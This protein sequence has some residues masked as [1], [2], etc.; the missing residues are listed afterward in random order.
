MNYYELFEISPAAPIEIIESAYKKTAKKYHPDTY[1]GADKKFAE[2]QMKRLNEAIAIL[3][4]VEKRKNYDAK[5]GIAIERKRGY[6]RVIDIAD[7][8]STGERRNLQFGKY[9]W[10]VLDIQGGKALIITEDIIERRPYNEIL[11]EVNWENCTLR[12]DYLNIEFL[13][14]FTFGE[15][16]RIIETN[17]SYDNYEKIFLLDYKE[18]GKYFGGSADRTAKYGDRA[19]WWW[20]RSDGAYSINAA[21]VYRD[22]VI[23]INGFD[24]NSNG[25]IRPALWIKLL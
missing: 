1:K 14:H 23:Y 22:G 3:R 25:G 20:L 8:I 15:R 16:E 4:D 10:R 13:R 17:N 19:V 11:R 18:A 21:Y 2:E 5:I 9:R 6:S 12:N 24:I 7:K